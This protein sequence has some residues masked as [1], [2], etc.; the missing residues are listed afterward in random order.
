MRKISVTWLI[1]CHQLEDSL[2]STWLSFFLSGKK[3][4][5][6]SSSVLKKNW[7]HELQLL[8][9]LTSVI[10]DHCHDNSVAIH[11]LP[12]MTSVMISVASPV[13]CW[14]TSW[15]LREELTVSK[16]CLTLDHELIYDCFRVILLFDTNRFLPGSDAWKV[17]VIFR[18]SVI[19][20]LW[21]LVSLERCLWIESGPRL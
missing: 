17:W 14:M 9:T 7:A 12:T 6:H 5:K 11:S 8:H 21:F 4:C 18:N 1:K 19:Y 16:C 20:R 2:T 10:S 15:H 3:N 13:L